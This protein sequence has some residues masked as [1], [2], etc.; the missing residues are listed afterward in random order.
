MA[1]AESTWPEDQHLPRDRYG[2]LEEVFFSYSYTPIRLETGTVG[3]VF[4]LAIET[5]A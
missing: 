4:C 5:T 3:G 2:F 1:N